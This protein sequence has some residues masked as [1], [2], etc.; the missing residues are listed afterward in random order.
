MLTTNNYYSFIPIEIPIDYVSSLQTRKNVSKKPLFSNTSFCKRISETSNFRN[1]SISYKVENKITSST[2]EPAKRKIK[3]FAFQQRAFY[4]LNQLRNKPTDI[5]ESFLFE[6]NSDEGAILQENFSVG[7]F[8]NIHWL[9]TP[10]P[11]YSTQN[12]NND[13]VCK[14]LAP[15]NIASAENNAQII[16]KQPFTQKEADLILL[17]IAVNDGDGFYVDGNKNWNKTNIIDWWAKSEER[18]NYIIE[19]YKNELFIPI[20]SYSVAKIPKQRPTPE[21]YKFWLDFYRYDIKQYLEWYIYKIENTVIELPEL[22]FDWCLKEKLD[23]FLSTKF[24]S[25]L[26]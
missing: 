8:K 12:N 26:S 4:N 20:S 19:A 1:F 22:R 2:T 5:T 15:T 14:L 9:N 16:F 24:L 23:K 6:K 18:I 21:N 17:A 10:G 25:S 3:E 7:D 11:I 13:N